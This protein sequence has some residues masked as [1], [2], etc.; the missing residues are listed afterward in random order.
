MSSRTECLSSLLTHLLKTTFTEKAYFLPWMMSLL[1]YQLWS[2][3]LASQYMCFY[4]MNAD[5]FI[6][7]IKASA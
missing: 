7:L 1:G 5:A 2:Y 4:L 6:N 3:I